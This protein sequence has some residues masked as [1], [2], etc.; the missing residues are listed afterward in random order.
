MAA[1]R[2]VDLSAEEINMV[3]EN[4]VLWWPIV[5]IGKSAK[6]AFLFKKNIK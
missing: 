4:A 5:I 6:N 2:F 1:S 3:K